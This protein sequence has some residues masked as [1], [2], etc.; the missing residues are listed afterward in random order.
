MLNSG[1]EI[2]KKFVSICTKSP[3]IYK[4]IGEN[5][6]LLYIGKAKSLKVRLADYTNINGMSDKTQI[7]VSKLTRIETISTQDEI[8]AILLESNLIRK[9]KPKY[10]ILLKDDKAFPYIVIDE[11]TNYPRI[12]RHR[13]KKDI[14]GAYFGPFASALKAE[15]IIDILQKAFL[16]R[17]CSDSFFK[18]RNRPCILYQIKKCSAPCVAKI[19]QADYS[20][21]VKQAKKHLNGK[22]TSLQQILKKS[23]NQASTKLDYEKAAVYRDRLNALSLIKSKQV[24]NLQGSCA[25]FDIVAVASNEDIFV[26]EVF[27]IRESINFGNKVYHLDN[28]PNSTD[29]E[30]ITAFLF[31]FYQKNAAPEEILITHEVEDRDLLEKFLHEYNNKKIKV[32]Y[33]VR[34]TKKD[35]LQFALNNA[36]DTLRLKSHSKKTYILTLEKIEKF[37]GITKSL[38]RIEIYDNSHFSGDNPVG[39]RVVYDKSGFNKSEYRKYNVKTLNHKSDDYE[40]FRGI[41]SRRFKKGETLPELII[42]DGGA[43]QVSTANLVCKEL[44]LNDIMIIGMAKGLKRN[45]GEETIYLSNGGKIILDK[46]DKLKQHLQILR[47]EAHR[48]AITFSRKKT[49][50]KSMKSELDNIVGIGLEKKLSLMNFFGSLE[51]IKKASIDDLRNA[52]LISAKNAENIYKYFHNSL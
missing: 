52:K 31:N 10:N 9:F 7:I 35:L 51:S 24:A 21:L 15:N 37:F 34:G 50:E 49:Q 47:D 46:N 6:Q 5:D 12:A 16:I 2:I 25:N 39:V 23:M 26:V 44:G 29:S 11:T 42:M 40:M 1:V 17:T 45:S 36:Q 4:M 33:S 41:L 8:E 48:F 22:A 27:F 38:N 3:G 32:S 30:L 20:E 18:S 19:S 28:S 43:G 13:G 14:K